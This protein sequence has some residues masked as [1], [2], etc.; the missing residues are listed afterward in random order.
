MNEH[1]V[2]VILLLQSSIL[3]IIYSCRDTR[4]YLTCDES[5]DTPVAT[6]DGDTVTPLSY[7]C[8]EWQQSLL[9]KAGP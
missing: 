5:A 8:V 3:I 2:K 4:V 9:I 1:H 6:T 7:V